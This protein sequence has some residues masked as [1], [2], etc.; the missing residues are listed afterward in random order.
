M[1]HAEEREEKS[2]CFFLTRVRFDTLKTNR[3][4][5]V[6]QLNVAGF[7]ADDDVTVARSKHAT[8]SVARIEGA[9]A[10]VRLDIPHFDLQQ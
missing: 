5:D 1:K 7:R 8:Q 6:V 4:R 3:R 10:R 9:H 2:V